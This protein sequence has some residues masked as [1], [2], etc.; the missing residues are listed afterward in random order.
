MLA[1]LDI[2]VGLFKVRRL[3]RDM[4]LV[5]KQPG[6]HAYKMSMNEQPDIPNQLNREFDVHSTNQV[7]C[8]DITYIWTGHKWSY[9]AVVIDLYARR[10]IGWACQK[11]QM[12]L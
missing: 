11:S 3:M 7:W 9:L 10:A 6:S 1:D 8:G 12:Q 2:D 4:Q 5:S